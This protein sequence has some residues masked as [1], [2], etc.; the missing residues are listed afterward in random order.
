[1]M[2]V[3]I[4]TYPETALFELGCAVELFAL[5]RPEFTDWYTTDV[6]SFET[7]A[8]RATGG[9]QL[10]ALTVD[11]LSPY[12]MLVVPGWPVDREPDDSLLREISAL[13]QRGGTVLSF[14]TGA[15]LLAAAGLLDGKSATTHWRYA[16]RFR[17]R[18]PEV[19]YV[20]DV[21]Y[22]FEDKVGCA[23]GSSAALD[24]GLA[25]IREHH[26]YEIV[27]QVAR[28]L[29]MAAH[30]SGG[31]SQFVE[32]PVPRTSNRFA[33]TLDWAVKNLAKGISVS[34]LARRANMSRRSFD[35]KFRTSLNMSANHWLVLQ[36]LQ[37]ARHLLESSH[38]PMEQVASLS[39]FDNAITMRHHFRKHLQCTP[40]RFRG[41]F[42]NASEH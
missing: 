7:H 40:T 6:I 33:E 27:N 9:I 17:D 31:Q 41:Q 22:I 34:D 37:L 12:D 14:C 28:R 2:R 24:L 3:A 10:K 42:A 4:L 35:R 36:K 30:R 29:V 5:S 19:S 21:L 26:G 23:A 8:V 1:M 20:D 32:T 39:G 25:V 16:D 11:G 18:F 15:F 38:Q 13:H